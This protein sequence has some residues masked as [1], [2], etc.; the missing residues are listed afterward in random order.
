MPKAPMDQSEILE[1][2]EKIIDIA[3]E[4]VMEEGYQGLS[5]RNIGS[6]IGMT[7]ANLYNYFSNKDE[8]NIAIRTRAGKM[9][10][11]ELSRA[12]NEGKDISGK[13]ALMIEAYMRFGMLRPNY[14]SVLFD[15]GA[16][17]YA[18]YVGS[19][20]ESLAQSEKE[21]SEQSLTL[22]AQC[23]RDLEREGY[24][25]PENM[26]S[27]WVMIWAQFHGL[28]SL[29]NN[30]LLFEVISSPEENLRAAAKLAYDV[31]FSYLRRVNL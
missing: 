11:D 14:Y 4:I 12:Y 21:S 26:D 1:K 31:I 10:F 8:L 22:M 15:I 29:Y 3:A 30:R 28:I 17:K 18:D 19:P 20:L 23:I 27:F 13:M 9:L 25:L 16:P 6:R 2:K 24:E 7:A 5:M